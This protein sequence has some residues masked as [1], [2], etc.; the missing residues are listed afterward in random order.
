M[1]FACTQSSKTITI[2]EFEHSIWELT[3]QQRLAYNLSPLLYDEGL[4]DLARLH[5][6]NMFN[7]DF[8]AHKDHLGYLVSDRNPKFCHAG[9]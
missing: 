6:K 9:S 7:F 1:L 4:A 8:F 5:S 3:N 2:S